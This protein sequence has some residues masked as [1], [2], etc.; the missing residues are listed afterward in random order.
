MTPVLDDEIRRALRTWADQVPVGPD[1]P[2]ECMTLPVPSV[3]DAAE[4]RGSSGR[5]MAAAAAAALVLGGLTL[6]RVAPMTTSTGDEP[7]FEGSDGAGGFPLPTAVVPPPVSPPPSETLP[8]GGTPLIEWAAPV[9]LRPD[10]P[11]WRLVA[12]NPSRTRPFTALRFGHVDG[13]EFELSILRPGLMSE[14]RNGAPPEH[15]VLVRGQTGR[16]SD[17][18]GFAQVMWEEAGATWSLRSPAYAP[19]GRGVTRLSAEQLVLMAA[20][21]EMVTPAE[22]AQWLPPALVAVMHDYPGADEITWNGDRSFH[23]RG[24]QYFLDITPAEIPVR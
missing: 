11:G 17:D 1:R 14:P 7:Q 3:L 22:N 5:W 16:A 19:E 12:Y 23:L 4:G 20:D 24:R 8:P 15:D 2:E 21:F 9:V 6:F 13:R 18:R 10:E